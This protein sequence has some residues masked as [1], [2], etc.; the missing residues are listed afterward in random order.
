MPLTVFAAVMLAASA[1]AELVGTEP[2]VEWTASLQPTSSHFS[3]ED[4]SPLPTSVSVDGSRIT[5]EGI[6][7]TPSGCEEVDLRART[8]G[9]VIELQVRIVEVRSSCSLA[10]RQFAYTVEGEHPRGEYR[11]IV[12]YEHVPGGG[13]WPNGVTA[14]TIVVI[15]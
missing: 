15:E 1:C 2:S 14:D 6:A 3:G 11:V 7:I 10:I 13:A 9:Q 8:T 4:L 5:L 12:R